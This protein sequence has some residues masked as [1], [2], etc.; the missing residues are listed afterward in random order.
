MISAV[1]HHFVSPVKFGTFKHPHSPAP[2]LNCQPRKRY[3]QRGERHCRLFDVQKFLQLL[4]QELTIL[5]HSFSKLIVQQRPARTIRSFRCSRTGH[6][7][8]HCRVNLNKMPGANVNT[9]QG[10]MLQQMLQI[11][12]Y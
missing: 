12:P 6:F 10:H 5:L 3:S 8:S 4:C 9:M 2:K 7:R 1:Q 11:L